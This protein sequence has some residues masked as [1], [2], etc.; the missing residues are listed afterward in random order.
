MHCILDEGEVFCWGNNEYGQLATESDEEQVRIWWY[1]NVTPKSARPLP[2]PLDK[3][4]D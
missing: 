1:F 3:V 4:F 2:F